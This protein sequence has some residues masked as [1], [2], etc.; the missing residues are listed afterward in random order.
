VE[1]GV[2]TASVPGLGEV[3]VCNGIATAQRLLE[4]P[5][6]RERFVAIEVMACVGGCLGGGGEPKSADPLVLQKRMQ[7][8][9]DVDRQS[10]RR[11]PHENQAV[12]A[13]YATQLGSPNSD[14]AHAL[15][16]T[17]YAARRSKRLLLMRLLD[18]V[19]RRDGPGAARL[20]HPEGCWSTASAHGD[21]HGAAQVDE[22]IRCR[23][24]P[25][26]YGPAYARHRMAAPADVDDMAVVSPTGERSLFALETASLAEAGQTRELILR[27]VRHPLPPD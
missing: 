12:Q 4:T 17:S 16:H 21:I 8:F 14:R 22:F 2:K 10:P 18:C 23:L 5:A 15:L 25:R 1:E 6:W 27:L 7:A 3:A 26:R 20:F 19:D 13:L 24:P 9:Y 11:R